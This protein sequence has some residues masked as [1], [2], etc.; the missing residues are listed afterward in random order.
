[1]GSRLQRAERRCL[2]KSRIPGKRA[3]SGGNKWQ[4]NSRM[5]PWGR[6]SLKAVR[7]PRCM[8][9]LPDLISPMYVGYVGVL[10]GGRVVEASCDPLST[11]ANEMRCE[12]LPCHAIASSKAGVRA[13]RRGLFGIARGATKRCTP[14]CIAYNILKRCCSRHTFG[15]L[16][17]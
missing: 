9:P 13:L 17:E 6:C 8:S 12:V 4:C 14:A 7:Y 16:C 15:R 10:L 5:W 1:V 2:L 3:I 11:Q